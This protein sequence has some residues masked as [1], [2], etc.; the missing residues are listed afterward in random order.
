MRLIA[1]TALAL[2]IAGPALAGQAVTLKMDIAASGPITL[3]D[4]FEG[5]GPAGKTV[6]AAPVTVGSVTLDVAAVQRAAF[7]AGLDWSNEQGVQRI[8]VHAGAASSSAATATAK[9]ASVEVLAYSH[10]LDAGEIIQ[11]DDL[12][13]AKAVAAPAGA[14]HDADQLIGKQVRRPLREGAIASNRDVASPTVIKKD[15]MVSV[16][17]ASDGVSLTMTGKAVGSASVGDTLGVIN[18]ST[19]KVIQAV[20]SGP[21]Q[22]VIG[23]G[24]ERLRAQTLVSPSQIALR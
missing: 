11:A 14:P 19:K 5:A 22:A 9:T 7:R 12:T 4:L 13:W 16:T 17:F 2:V 20:A 10:S 23:P 21:G 15:D 6:V 1:L 18:P 3:G 24:A 8:V